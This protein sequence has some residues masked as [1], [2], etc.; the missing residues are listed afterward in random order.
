MMTTLHPTTQLNDRAQIVLSI[1]I[2]DLSQTITQLV[3]QGIHFTINYSPMPEKYMER[4]DVGCESLGIEPIF[5]DDSNLKYV[6]M[7]KIDQVIQK[8]ISAGTTPLI[9]EVAKATEMK[10]SRVKVKLMEL[11]GK[12]FYQYYL[13]VKMEYAAKLLKTGYRASQVS[14][15]IGYN[16]PIKFNKMFQKYY[17]MT[18]YRY[19]KQHES[20]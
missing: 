9:Q 20:D 17:G 5:Q 12:T 3:Q 8:S 18:P 1:E 11:T 6:F 7:Q 10:C 16:Q 4:A 19:R 2:K 14:E 13:I 15:K